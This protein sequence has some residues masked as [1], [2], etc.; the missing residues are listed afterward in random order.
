MTI[1]INT[2]ALLFPAIT[3]LLLAYTNRFLGVANLIRNLHKKHLEFPDQVIIIEQI[4]NLTSRVR[5]IK[6]MQIC[7]VFSFVFC[8]LS[9]FMVFSDL[10]NF[11]NYT[12]GVSMLSLL[13]SLLIS[14]REL[15]ISTRALEMELKDMRQF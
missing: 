10:S 6:W 15:Q 7:G 11:G 5:L 12:F 3:L 1:T 13:I 14:L 2:P 4:Q 9:M 8:V